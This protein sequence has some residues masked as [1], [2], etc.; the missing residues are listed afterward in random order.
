MSK[1]FMG[2]DN[3]GTVCKVALYDNKGNALALAS[4]K[5]EMIYPEPGHTEKDMGEFWG[6]N[7]EAIAEVVKISGVDP[8]DIAGIA[9]TGHGNGMFLVDA[10]GD[11]VGNGIISTDSRAKDIVDNW[12]S[13]GTFEKINRKTLQSIWA[14]QPVALLNWFRENNPAVLEQSRWVLMCK[15]YIRFKLTGE[16]YAEITDYSGTNLVNVVEANYDD[17]LL[18]DF[19]L[20]DYKDMFPPLKRSTDICGSVT[21]ETAAATGLAEG[22]PVMGGF[23]DIDACAIATGLT[24]DKNIS[25]IAGTWSINQFISKKPVGSTE[26]FMTSIYAIPGYWLVSEASATSAS[27]LEWFMK[28][29]M[30]CED[31]DEVNTSVASIRPEDSDVLFVPFLYASSFGDLPASF[32]GLQGWHTKAH[33]LRAVYEGIV[34]GHKLHIDRLMKYREPAKSVRISGG[35]SKS[36][37]WIQMFADILQMPIEITEAEEIGTLG[38]A[39]GAA[40][41]VDEYENFENA[42]EAMVRV[43]RTVQPN[44]DMAEI[45]T[46]KYD[47]FYR[48]LDALKNV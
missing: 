33:M 5:V 35:A 12:Y 38:A 1:Y 30:E 26:L 9:A 24:D 25:L 42:T 14:A 10:E 20:L 36:E 37:V 34:F 45:Y 46:E 29:L 16:A 13:D 4:R 31:Y 40:V 8:K 19:D 7:V 39:I 22:T 43:T 44:K 48:Y 32:F 28:N 6:A 11:A 17:E 18:K 47:K 21:K 27:N 3:G 2:I 15:D 23:F 41:G